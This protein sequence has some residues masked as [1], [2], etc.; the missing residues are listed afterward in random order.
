[1][2]RARA[3]SAATTWARLLRE[4]V[5][6]SAERL[7]S[8]AAQLDALA[9][10]AAESGA[11]NESVDRVTTAAEHL[12]RRAAP[13]A[14]R[15]RRLTVV[16]EELRRGRYRWSDGPAAALADLAR[17]AGPDRLAAGAGVARV[18]GSSP[19]VGTEPSSWLRC[20]WGLDRVIAV[21]AGV[22]AAPVVGVL[23]VLVRRSSP[24]PGLVGLSRVGIGGRR[25]TMWKVR[26]MRAPEAGAAGGSP[27]T[28]TGDARVTPLGRRIRRLRID[29]LPQL[30]NVA[31]GEMALLGPRPETPEY[32]E[33]D[34]PRWRASLSGRPGI[35]GASQLLVHAWESSLPDTAFYL[36]HVLPV[37]LAVDRWYITNATPS[38]DLLI[39]SGT[40][41]SLLFHR[42]RARLVDRIRREVPEAAVVPASGGVT[43]ATVPEAEGTG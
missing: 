2:S 13:P 22:V 20:R 17:P 42:P 12:R 33:L 30:W 3:G 29:E 36:R 27:L 9:K 15:R 8:R 40:V 5:P 38:I 19:A 35:A 4:P 14:D 32:V 24:G 25:F 16:G 18:M 26:T 23:A 41:G 10:R 31:R 28:L 21:G 11:S 43:P 7:L 37:K 34:D 6:A 1:M 39:V